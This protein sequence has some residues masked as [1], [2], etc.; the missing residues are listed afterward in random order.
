MTRR[1]F[2]LGGGAALAGASS[3]LLAACGGASS[4]PSAS[5]GVSAAGSA[6]VNLGAAQAHISA[7]DQL[8]FTP[9]QQTVSAGQVVQ[10][11]NTGSMQHT[12]TFDSQ[13]ALSDPLLQAGA[14]WEVKFTVPG[15]YTYHCTLHPGMTGTIVAK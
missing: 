13:S 5:G 3:L 7:T 14:N 1:I 2:S 15:T 10:W 8:L 4:Q 11:S 9:S 6:G 12:I